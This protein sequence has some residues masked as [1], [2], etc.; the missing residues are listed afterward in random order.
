M[1]PRWILDSLINGA[2]NAVEVAAAVRAAG[3]VIGVIGI[4]GVD[5]PF[6]PL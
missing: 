1:T 6:P 4:T 2:I 5:W 3:L